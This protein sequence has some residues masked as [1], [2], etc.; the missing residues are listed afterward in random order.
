MNTINFEKYEVNE[1]NMKITFSCASSYPYTRWDQERQI[2]FNQI[3]IVNEEAV[4]LSRLNN[5][6]PVLFNHDT[7]RLLG[8]VEKAFIIDDKLFVTVR[9]SPNDRFSKRIFDDILVGLIKNVSIG[10][11]VEDYQDKVNDKGEIDRYVKRWMVYQCSIVSIPADPTIGIRKLEIQDKIKETRNMEKEE[12]KEV[13]KPV[14]GEEKPEEEKACQTEEVKSCQPEEEKQ[15]E[16]SEVEELKKQL[17]L[18]KAENEKLQRL[19]EAKPEEKQEQPEEEKEKQIDE[20]EE[21]KAIGKD[22]NIPEEQIKSAIDKNLTV[23]EFKKQIKNFNIINKKEKEMNSFK[24]YIENRDFSEP[25]VMRDFTGFSPSQ[26]VGTEK[27]PLEKVLQ[28]KLGLAGYRVLSGLRSNITIPVQQTR[29]T[30]TTPGINEASTDSNPTFANVTLSPVKFVGSTLVGKEMLV[31]ST[32]DVIAFISDSIL[33]EIALKLEA[34][35][36]SKVA[37]GAANTVTYSAIDAVTYED[38]LAMEG[39]LGQYNLEAINFVMASNTRAILKGI[40]KIGNYPSFLIEDNYCNGYEAR[41]SG[42]ITDSNIYF[43]SWDKLVLGTWSG[44]ELIVDPFTNAKSGAVQIVGS[45]CAD[46]AV[47]QPDAFVIGKV[48]TS[49]S[50]SGQE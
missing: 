47:I 32:D 37:A 31:N 50:S 33:T 6:A 3:L 23:R 11:A 29:N 10:Y 2:A 24:E 46:A 13:E 5:G 41:V 43:G 34:Y 19:C 35:M 4:D 20:K 49:S 39:Y 8:I 16:C 44:L 22:F 21:I 26:L 30:I 9:F 15:D 7:N 1:Q 12:I 25:Y 14:E 48:Q 27:L 40:A 18:I 38:I 17:E 45:L 28:K 36:L 42:A